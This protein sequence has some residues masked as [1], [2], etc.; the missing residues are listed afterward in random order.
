MPLLAEPGS[1]V[2][3]TPGEPRVD[4]DVVPFATTAVAPAPGV[5]DERRRAWN[6]EQP[7][8]VGVEMMNQGA[9]L[10]E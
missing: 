9:V 2:A 10:T 6:L 4:Q 8:G 5:G 1:D 7:G 3:L